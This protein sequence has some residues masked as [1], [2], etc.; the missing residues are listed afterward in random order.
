MERTTKIL[1]T[2]GEEVTIDTKLNIK[3]LMRINSDFN[4]DE[5]ATL[6]FS[7]KE[8]FK[9]S[10]LQAHQAV[11]IAYRQANMNNYM[12]FTEFTEL[13]DFDF[14]VGTKVFGELLSS[15]TKP[16]NYRQSIAKVV[17]KNK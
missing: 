6:T 7:R 13:W 10:L 12:D 11:Y 5:F 14:T 8:D 1:L 3:K 16:N 2:T 9:I 4:T 15:S 17:K